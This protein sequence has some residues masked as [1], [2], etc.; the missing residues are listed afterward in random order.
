MESE[1]FG[2][3]ENYRDT[4]DIAFRLGRE[5][6]EAKNKSRN[7]IY[8]TRKLMAHVYAWHGEEFDRAIDEGKP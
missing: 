8:E 1:S 4:I 6:E 7:E 5:A 2:C 3:F